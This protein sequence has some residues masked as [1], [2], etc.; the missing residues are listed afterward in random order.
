ML[1]ILI[2]GSNYAPHPFVIEFV[3]DSL[4][5]GSAYLRLG[6]T[7]EFVN[8]DERGLAS[9]AEELLHVAQV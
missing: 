2:V 3:K 9:V 6:T 1:E 4:G 8:K 5:D 7:A